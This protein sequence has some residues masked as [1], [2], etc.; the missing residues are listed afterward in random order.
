MIG[1]KRLRVNTVVVTACAA[2]V[3]ATVM[4]GG[5]AR[6]DATGARD[7]AAD[8]KS[9]AGD[10][11]PSVTVSGDDRIARSL[12]WETPEVELDPDALAAERERAQAALAANHLYE[13]AEAAIPLYLAIL[14]LAPD[15]AQAKAGLQQAMQALIVAGDAALVQAGDQ[16]DA[17]RSAHRIAAVA[18]SVQAVHESLKDDVVPAYLARVDAADRL[19]DLNRSAELQMRDGHFG[20]DSG[21][22]LASLRE[23]LRLQPG[24]PRAMQ[25]LAAVESGLIR[26]AES[27]AGEGDFDA[28][29]G[30]LAHAA[31]VRSDSARPDSAPDTIADARTRIQALRDARISQLRDAG[32]AALQQRG[33]IA[34]A[35]RNLAQM[36]L[37]AEPGNAAAAELRQRID[38]T[39]HYG[40]FRP[41][42]NFTDAL[43]RGGRGPEMVVVPH[44][45]FRM[46]APEGQDDANESEQPAHYIRFDRGFA[47][48]RNEVT[49]DEFRRFVNASDYKPRASRRG[50][51]MTYEERSGNFVRRSGVDWQSDYAGKPAA[52][53]AP[54]LHV[55]A[56]DAEAYAA[57]LSE[58]SG[59]NYRLPSEAEFEYALR[60]GGST[61][62]PWGDGA[63]PA[64]VGN[65]T[66]SRDRSPGG[67]GWRNA[68]DGYGDGF[69]GPAPVGQFKPN[70]Y[71]LHDMAGNVSEW[72]V[73]C[74]HDSYRRAPED[75]EAWINP[76]C[77]T[78][79][80]RGGAWASAPEQTR[81]AWRAAAGADTTNPR[82]GFR[83]VREL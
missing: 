58:Q 81:S 73:D 83:V 60:A 5:C 40:I 7:A 24:Q 16:I 2:V 31:K 69:W 10:N 76:G 55:S 18:R 26:R 56:R 61:R 11:R 66:G 8:G 20:E 67:R 52:D 79:V 41:G 53:N 3:L 42:Q 27:A 25:G 72:V 4:L 44:G 39:T 33:G 34:D 19:W 37:I 46:G 36:L 75:G 23:A 14:E 43:S 6:D 57:W 21:G 65:L 51:S 35:H 12:S 63:P 82:I 64:R 78:R 29:Q 80:I 15:D 50:H 71:G 74:W 9:G 70:A 1:S 22:A 32:L 17:L 77:R 59:G 68:F 48:S 47:M 49:V 28:A 13:D 38:L 45:A 62:Y 54:V 30:W